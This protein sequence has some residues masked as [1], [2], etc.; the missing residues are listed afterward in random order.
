MFVPA[1]NEQAIDE[2]LQSLHGTHDLPLTPFSAKKVDGKKLYE[3]AREGNPK[4][5]NVPM[6]IKG[7]E[8]VSYHFPLLQLELHVGKGTYI[9]SIAHYLGQHF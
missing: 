4:F 8:I 6:T 1:P 2:F 5:L 3:Y 9:R 7:H